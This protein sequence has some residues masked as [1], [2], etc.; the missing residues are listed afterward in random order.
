VRR[1]RYE[2]RQG[3]RPGEWKVWDTHT[4]TVVFGGEN[5]TET[6]ATDLARRLNEAWRSLY[7]DLDEIRLSKAIEPAEEAQDTPNICR[8]Q[9]KLSEWASQFSRAN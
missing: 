5:M 8:G 7:P 4:D 9:I 2:I 6:A 3:E 1:D